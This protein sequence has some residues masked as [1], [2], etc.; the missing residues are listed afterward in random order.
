MKQIGPDLGG[1]L[2]KWNDGVMADSGVIYCIPFKSDKVLK[3][4]TNVGDNNGNVI[5]TYRRRA[6]VVNGIQ[7][8]DQKLTAA[9]I[10][11]RIMPVES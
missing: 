6:A 3:I 10:A 8:Q 4:D 5:S 7:E 1:G 11:C 2:F 9:F